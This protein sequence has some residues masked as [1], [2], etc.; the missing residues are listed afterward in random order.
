MSEQF[1]SAAASVAVPQPDAAELIDRLVAAGK[2]KQAV[3]LAKEQHKRLRTPQSEQRLVAAYVSRIEQFLSKGSIPEAQAL[4]SLVQ[5]RFPS[6]RPR[7]MELEFPLLAATGKIEQLLLPLAQSDVPPAIH[8]RIDDAIRRYVTDLPA[9]SNCPALPAD[10]PLRQQ[11]AAIRRAFEAAT[12]GPVTDEQ[13]ALT[14]VPRRSPLAEWKLLVRAFVAFYREQDEDCKRAL[15]A[16]SPDAAARRIANALGGMLA[17]TP[18][19]A[20]PAAVLRTR[21]LSN[22]NSLREAIQGLE[23]ALEGGDL[24]RLKG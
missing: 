8:Q 24:P 4:L 13:E 10:H 19:P 5:E 1:Q 12:S 23:R 17:G 11:A 20:G 3:E 22:P 14:Q 21:V 18:S 9:L 6:H 16:I 7:L 2:C 15:D